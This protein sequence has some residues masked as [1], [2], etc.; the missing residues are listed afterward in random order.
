MDN[1]IN[2]NVEEHIERFGYSKKTMQIKR[3]NKFIKKKNT[4]TMKKS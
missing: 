2:Q 3:K 1:T 4:M